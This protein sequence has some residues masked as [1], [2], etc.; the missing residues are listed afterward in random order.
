[1]QV[2][3]MSW[4][5]TAIF[6]LLLV[7]VPVS[8]GMWYAGDAA[9]VFFQQVC[10]ATQVGPS[11]TIGTDARGRFGPAWQEHSTCALRVCR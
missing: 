10:T 2:L 11:H 1:L 9:R 8:V 6:S 3:V 7:N 5:I 4:A